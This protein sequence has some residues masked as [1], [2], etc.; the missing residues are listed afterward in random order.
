MSTPSAY[1]LSG[2]GTRPV[3]QDRLAAPST[4]HGIRCLPPACLAGPLGKPFNRNANGVVRPVQ[5][6]LSNVD[7]EIAYDL[8]AG[9]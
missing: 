3:G 2:G 1:D 7:A 9:V 8:P 4:R 6:V 5:T